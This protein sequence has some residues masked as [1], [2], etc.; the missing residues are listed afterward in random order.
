MRQGNQLARTIEAREHQTLR[1][2]FGATEEVPK[3]S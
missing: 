2:E 1:Q 3:N